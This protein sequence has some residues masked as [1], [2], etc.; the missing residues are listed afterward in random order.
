MKAPRNPHPSIYTARER[1]REIVACSWLMMV[2]SL[3]QLRNAD[4]RMYDSILALM[5]VAE[6]DES[7]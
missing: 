5:L 7:S 2:V 6:H 4:A 3:I 1:E